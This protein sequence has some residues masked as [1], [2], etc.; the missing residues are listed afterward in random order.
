MKVQRLVKDLGYEMPYS[1]K[2]F[3]LHDVRDQLTRV[4][5]SAF[6]RGAELQ[7]GISKR[8]TPD[9]AEAMI[10]KRIALLAPARHLV[11]T[12][13]YLF[14]SSPKGG[15]TEY[16]DRLIRL[17]EPVL[18]PD[19]TLTCVV[20]KSSSGELQRSF[21]S[22][23]QQH[24]EGVAITIIVS[25]DFHDRFWIADGDRGVVVGA[26]LNGIGKKIFFLDELEYSDV[27]EIVVE[28]EALDL[29]I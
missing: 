4:G 11:I 14:P 29:S 23:L 22:L 6:L 24:V 20:N 26:S 25:D 17:V 18:E 13:P 27:R 5:P 12:D 10:A 16:V 19:A 15:A 9:N 8:S 28:L 7:H 21:S 2:S 1:D 3:S